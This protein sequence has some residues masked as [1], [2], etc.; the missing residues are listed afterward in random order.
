MI[1]GDRLVRVGLHYMRNGLIAEADIGAAHL[2]GAIALGRH[3]RACGLMTVGGKIPAAD[4]YT[5]CGECQN[6]CADPKIA[7]VET[8]TSH[9]RAPNSVECQPN[10]GRKPKGVN[11]SR[12]QENE[13]A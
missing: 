7:L 6:G 11:R 8:V 4:R 9:L 10:M 5:D 3:D 1:C 12:S 2:L 13:P